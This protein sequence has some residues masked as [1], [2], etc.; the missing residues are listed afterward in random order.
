MTIVVFAA[1]YFLSPESPLHMYHIILTAY[2]PA[3]L[4]P[5]CFNGLSVIL[6]VFSL[7]PL[8]NYIY[9]KDFLTLK[10]W[11]YFFV[12]KLVFDFAGRHG[13]LLEAAGRVTIDVLGFFYVSGNFAFTKK[14]ETVQLYDM[15]KGKSGE[16][17]E[18]DLFTVGASKVN[19]FAGQNGPYWTDLDGSGDLSWVDENGN[20]LDRS[21]ADTNYDGIVDPNETAELSEEAVGFALA[22]VNFALA[23]MRAHKPTGPP[24]VYYPAHVTMVSPG[25][26]NDI[27]YTAKKAGPYFNDVTVEYVNGTALKAA[28]NSTTRKFTVTVV[29]GVTTAADIITY[30]ENDK[31]FTATAA[32][33]TP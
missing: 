31:F 28:Y 4:F 24:P 5:Y 16:E 22:E 27:K 33:A 10:F 13:R 21:V 7:V 19:A 15:E 29:P 17:V 26:N 14:T 1:R 18:V 25:P 6:N 23:V 12:F 3:F 11:R 2:H 30:M 32:E 8:H 9:Q 20:T